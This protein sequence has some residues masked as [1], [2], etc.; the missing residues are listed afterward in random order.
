MSVPDSSDWSTL[1][2]RQAAGDHHAIRTLL[3][4]I[5]TEPWV[6]SGVSKGGLATIAYG[7]FYPDDVSASIPYVAPV[8]TSFEDQR[9]YKFLNTAG[10]PECRAKHL[11]LQRYLLSEREEALP[12]L[13]WFA[14]GTGMSFEYLGVEAAFEYAVLEY[15][16]SFWQWGWDCDAV[17][18]PGESEAHLDLALEHV[19]DV[20]G[21]SLYSDQGIDDTG[22]H[23]YQAASQTGYYGFETEPFADL[24]VVLPPEPHA[25]FLPPGVE[26]TYDP[27]VLTEISD[28]VNRR[29]NNFIFLYGAVDTW[30]AGAVEL[31]GGTNSLSFTMAGRHH[32]DARIRNLPPA[33]KER[34]RRTLEGWLGTSLDKERWEGG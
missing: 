31:T 29:S 6:S 33:D 17:P 19:I 13:H 28:W 2:V 12:R 11:A 34:V 21:L 27:S 7:Y 32:G 5:Y 26:A 18:L 15:P 4:A 25:A 3:G 10:T 9:I 20:V 30:T 24:L 14:K 8:Q 1:D 22:A 16:F 23:Y